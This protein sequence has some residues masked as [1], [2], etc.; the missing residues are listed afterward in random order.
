ME[1]EYQN[2]LDGLKALTETVAAPKANL[3]PQQATAVSMAASPPNPSEDSR[4][5]AAPPNPAPPSDDP[6]PAVAV[7]GPD[8]LPGEAP[9]LEELDPQEMPW[10]RL[11]Y[12]AI[13]V[14]ARPSQ[15]KLEYRTL[16]RQADDLTDE[17]WTGLP[18]QK[19]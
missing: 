18:D 9:E 1:A 5:E 15:A 4:P 16:L 13:E 14:Q 8:P 6:L 7:A 3:A 2:F 12:L 19:V 11:K 10:Q 17:V